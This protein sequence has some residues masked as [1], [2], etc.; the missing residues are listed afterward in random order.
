M[1][2]H[3]IYLNSKMKI[4]EW[5]TK[6]EERWRIECFGDVEYVVFWLG[7]L[8]LWRTLL[9]MCVSVCASLQL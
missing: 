7:S 3:F 4:W 2:I 8:P 9:I 5:K 1:S 6:F